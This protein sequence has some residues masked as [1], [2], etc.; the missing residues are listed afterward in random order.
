VTL[1]DRLGMFIKLA[2]HGPFLTADR[3]RFAPWPGR[4][5]NQIAGHTS[6]EENLTPRIPEQIMAALLRAAVF[7]VQTAARDLIAAD[8]ELHALTAAL[9]P[10][11]CP[12]VDVPARLWAFVTARRAE[13]RGLPALPIR[14]AGQ[15]ILRLPPGQQLL[16]QVLSRLRR[17]PI[18]I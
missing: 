13:R 6:P 11:R 8:H 1:A 10:A 14:H 4:H 18:W 16:A 3:L 9:P 12:S 7:Y 5:A 17:L 2:A 15:S